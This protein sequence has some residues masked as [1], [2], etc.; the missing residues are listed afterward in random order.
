MRLSNALSLVIKTFNPKKI[1]NKFFR[2]GIFGAVLLSMVL[3]GCQEEKKTAP[4]AK[5]IPVHTLAAVPSNQPYWVEVFGQTEGNEAVLVYPQVTGPILERVYREGQAV[6]K[7]EPLFIIDP[8]PFEAVYE[9]AAAAAQQAQANLKQAQ[10]EAKRYTEL[11][12]VK[13]VSSKE[14]TDAVSSYEV[15]KANLQAALAKEKEAKIT[16]GYTTVKAPVDGVAGRSLVNPGTLVQAKSTQL[17][18]I[19]QEDVLKARFSLSDSQLHGYEIN[20]NSPLFVFNDKLKEPVEGK[21]NFTSIQVDPKT[22]TRSLSAEIPSVGGLLPGQY[23][24]VRL[25][26]GMQNGV[27]LIPQKAIR[28]LS[29]GTYSVYLLKD[30]KARATPITVGK[31]SGKDWIV[32]GGLKAGDEI[33]ID[34]IQRLKDK[35]TV[36]KISANNAPGKK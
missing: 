9:S 27:F 13:A 30:N 6:K 35:S 26:L 12:K 15:S 5:P 10:R 34:N 32:T 7:G 20:E 24:T 23:V 11:H 4:K 22:G 8:A 18:D 14:Y 3:C 1:M 25:T 28:Q 19:T 31:W 36:D 2:C 21:I 16:L 33:I 29:D 17:T